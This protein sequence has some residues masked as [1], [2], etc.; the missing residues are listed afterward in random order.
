MD[1][2]KGDALLVWERGQ[3]ILGSL[4][5]VDKSVGLEKSVGRLNIRHIETMA[6]RDA[7]QYL[8]V[9]LTLE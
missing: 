7:R 4:D 1:V 3:S 8:L 9:W 5:G 6:L 2:E